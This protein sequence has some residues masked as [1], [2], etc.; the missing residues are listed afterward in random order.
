MQIFYDPVYHTSFPN[1]IPL[2]KVAVKPTTLAI[3]VRNVKY[4]LR[5]T[6]RRIVFISG[7]PDPTKTKVNKNENRGQVY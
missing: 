7:I 2:P 1:G 6:P 3:R 4:S 5:T